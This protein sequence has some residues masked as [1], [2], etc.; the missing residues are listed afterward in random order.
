M[1]SHYPKGVCTQ[2]CPEEEM[3]ELV[4]FDRLGVSFSNIVIYYRREREG[5][6]HV[7]EMVPNQQNGNIPKADRNRIVKKFTRSAAGRS[8]QKVTNLRTLGALLE[9]INYLLHEY[10]VKTVVKT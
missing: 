8:S 3:I 6:L 2:M 4:I 5:L 1:D 10:V 9:T 7:L